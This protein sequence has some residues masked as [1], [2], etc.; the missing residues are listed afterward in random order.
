MSNPDAALPAARHGVQY[1]PACLTPSRSARAAASRHFT[2]LEFL[3][4]AYGY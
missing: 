2:G 3:L 4:A 1:E